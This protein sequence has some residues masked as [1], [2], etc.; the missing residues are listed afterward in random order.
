MNPPTCTIDASD[1]T[2]LSAA[3]ISGDIAAVRHLLAAGADV[4]ELNPISG[5]VLVSETPAIFFA[6][7]NRNYPMMELL[8]SE[9]A[10][11]D[12]CDKE[13]MTMLMLTAHHN[14]T[15]QMRFLLA[16]G[17][18]ADITTPDGETALH[19]AAREECKE[20]IGML[21]SDERGAK[22][23]TQPNAEGLTP[24]SLA[25]THGRW[26]N[27]QLLWAGLSPEEAQQELD[28]CSV[29]N[30]TMLH[31]AVQGK[32]QRIIDWLLEKG[33]RP[34][35]VDRIGNSALHSAVMQG[36]SRTV[37]AF[38]KA[39]ANV[40][41]VNQKGMSPL[42]CAVLNRHAHLISA[43]IAAGADPDIA[44]RD[45]FTPLHL[46][47][48][49]RDTKVM[50]ELLNNGANPN[51]AADHHITPFFMAANLGFKDG[52]KLLLDAGADS[53]GYAFTRISALEVAASCGHKTIVNLIRKDYQR[54]GFQPVLTGMDFDEMEE[55]IQHQRRLK[56][57]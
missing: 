36:S 18:R 26:E 30:C 4:N 47:I 37:N 29:D 53:T 6:Y 41:L 20:V 48:I 34:V 28:R 23:I 32:N 56:R 9:G 25:I 46:A 3:V 45:G 39:G 11:P 16:H 15:E 43:L 49:Q 55:F 8:L 14:Q 27:L 12:V 38:I 51:A 13:G 21:L 44:G 33:V 42:H 19:Y 35:T 54:R 5:E 24:F 2:P 17:A 22:L 52:V 40:N 7:Y 50:K 10:N 1:I 57:Q 31:L